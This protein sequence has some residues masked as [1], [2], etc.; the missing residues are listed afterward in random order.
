MKTINY[1]IIFL[2]VLCSLFSV[3]CFSQNYEWSWAKSGGGSLKVNN[4]TSGGNINNNVNYNFEHINDILTDENNNYYFLGKI[5][6][7]SSHVDGNEVTT[8][9]NAIQGNN[10]IITSTACDGTYR[11]SRII[12]GGG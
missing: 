3:L 1:K 4:E 12:G 5:A 10:I 11:W 6:H 8:F 7:G 9:G 2:S